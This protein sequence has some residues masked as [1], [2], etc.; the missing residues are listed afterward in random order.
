MLTFQ[1]E[2][3]AQ[4]NEVEER[5]EETIETAGQIKKPG[6]QGCVS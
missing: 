3:A 1:V 4:D 6:D 2:G 5:E